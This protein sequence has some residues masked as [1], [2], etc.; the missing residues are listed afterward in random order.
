MKLLKNT[1]LL[2]AIVTITATPSRADEYIYSPEIC[3][4]QVALPGEPQNAKRCKPDNPEDC[5]NITSF[6]HVFGLDATVDIRLTCNK[7][8]TDMY[9]RYSGDVMRATLEGMVGKNKLGDYESH[10]NE[11]DEAKQA[12]LIGSGDVGNNNKIYM[13]QLWIGKESV[14]TIEGELIGGPHEEADDMFADILRSVQLKT[15]DS[16]ADDD[17]EEAEAEAEA[18]DSDSDEEDEDSD[19]E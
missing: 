6:T 5:S 11:T 15:P 13:A 14:F 9:E 12:V 17:T 3:E 7:A 2:L 8:E 18:D 4:F 1:A 16:A 10:Y 19:E